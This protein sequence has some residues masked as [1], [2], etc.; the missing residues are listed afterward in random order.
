MNATLTVLQDFYRDKLA[1]RLHHEV[2]ATAVST[3]TANNA[4]Q[5]VIAREEMQLGWIRLALEQLGVTTAEL[6]ARAES[7]ALT[8]EK[9]AF[10]DD[11]RRAQAFVDR[12]KPTVDEMTN[13]RHRSMLRVVL[14][15]TLEHKRFFEQALQ[16]RSD[17]LGRSMPGGGTE[18]AVMST[19]WVE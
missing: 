18:G 12:W 13:A 15:E 11:A 5:Y 10:E 16:G 6:S 7:T 2:A 1:M 9:A 8:N 19:R 3:Y 17:L 4:Y 14:G